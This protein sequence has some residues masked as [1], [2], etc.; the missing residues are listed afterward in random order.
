MWKPKGSEE[1][2]APPSPPPPLPS[3]PPPAPAETATTFV[4]SRLLPARQSQEDR[5]KLAFLIAGGRNPG[6]GVPRAGSA[7]AQATESGSSTAGRSAA[8][9]STT[10]TRPQAYAVEAAARA[11]ADRE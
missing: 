1:Q 2:D 9:G 11:Y 3:P 6:L 8:G 7:A 5:D 10:Q 4:N